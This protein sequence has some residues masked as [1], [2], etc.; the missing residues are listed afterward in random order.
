MGSCPDP[1]IKNDFNAI[2]RR[3]CRLATSDFGQIRTVELRNSA[4]FVHWWTIANIMEIRGIVLTFVLTLPKFWLPQA[5]FT[6]E[7]RRGRE[8]SR[9]E[10]S[11]IDEA[12]RVSSGE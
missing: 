7:K 1:A 9:R 10:P 4:R 12:R 5:D 3:K 8:W 2:Q 6:Y 11:D